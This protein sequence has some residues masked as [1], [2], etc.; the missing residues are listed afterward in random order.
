MIAP[1]MGTRARPARNRPA[2]PRTSLA[3]ALLSK[4]QQRVLGLLFG[5]PDRSFFAR[6]IISRT[7]AGSGAAQR[8]LAR[9]AE[10]GLVTLRRVGNQTHYQANPRAPIFAELRGIVLK[11]IAVA[12]PLRDALAPLA[13]RIDLALVYG[14]VAKRRDHAE[15][16]IDLLVVASDLMLEDLYAR[17]D[18]VERMLGRQIR[19]L[20]YSPEEF[21]ARQESGNAFLKKVLA[22]DTISIIGH[23]D[24]A[25]AS[26]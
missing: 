7:A 16:D 21:R 1:T 11:T 15:S 22:G 23:A 8:E 12:E 25:V 2:K 20:L 17:L 18:P 14:S 13:D 3:D 19:P 9:L 5:N 10:S 6:E 24:A 26:R 4:T